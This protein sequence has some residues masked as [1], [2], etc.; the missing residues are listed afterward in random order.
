M[1]NMISDKK[2]VPVP[3]RGEKFDGEKILRGKKVMIPLVCIMLATVSP[4]I[5]GV[6]TAPAEAEGLVLQEKVASVRLKEA[7]EAV[8]KK[9]SV[10]D[11]FKEAVGKNALKEVDAK[12]SLK[13]V[14]VQYDAWEKEEP[15]EPQ[16]ENQQSGHLTA[17]ERKNDSADNNNEK[18]IT[19]EETTEGNRAEENE[20]LGKAEIPESAETTEEEQES[21]QNP[22]QQGGHAEGDGVNNDD[23]LQT[24]VEGFTVSSPFGPRWGRFHTGIDLALAQ[25]NPI[26]AA[27]SGIVIFS[28]YSGGYGNLVKIDHGNGMQT[29]YAHCSQLLVSQG[30][31]VERGEEIALVGSTGNSTGPHLHFEVV[32]DGSCVNPANHLDLE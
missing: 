29:N 20:A 9:A 3:G 6:A 1:K 23:L 22:E 24:P 10:E 15:H 4:C 27:D 8:L 26:C 31:Q 13:K 18:I 17:Q 19:I 12:E 28:G 14:T 16:Q 2:T 21:R 5:V 11:A 32:I 25:G 30:Q 7:A